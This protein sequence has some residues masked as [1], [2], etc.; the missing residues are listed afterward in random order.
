MVVRLAIVSGHRRRFVNN[1]RG[2]GVK[3][4]VDG[5]LDCSQV[6]CCL[7]ALFE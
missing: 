2:S 4:A 1:V 7:V 3:V 5:E 6:V